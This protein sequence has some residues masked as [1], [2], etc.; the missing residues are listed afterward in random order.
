VVA[1]SARAANAGGPGPLARCG[2]PVRP[3]RGRAGIPRRRPRKAYSGR[4]AITRRIG[5]H[6]PTARVPDALPIRGRRPTRSCSRLSGP[7][8]VT[9]RP[10]AGLDKKMADGSPEGQP[11]PSTWPS[12]HPDTPIATRP[13]AGRGRPSR[14]EPGNRGP[15]VPRATRLAPAGADAFRRERRQSLRTTPRQRCPGIDCGIGDTERL[16]DCNLPR[17]SS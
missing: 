7:Y 15:F 16:A 9:S 3:E 17:L 10:A 14:R 11:Q 12:A 6:P 13:R 5:A 4:G 2:R 8:S 1:E